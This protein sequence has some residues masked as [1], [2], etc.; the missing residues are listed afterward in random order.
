MIVHYSKLSPSLSH[1]QSNFTLTVILIEENP[2]AL[3][4]GDPA[5]GQS[6]SLISGICA[7]VFSSASER[8]ADG[9]LPKA[10]PL[11]RPLKL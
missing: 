2:S 1:T 9:H 3:P 10:K 5:S 4:V 11:E 8:T 6:L 7:S